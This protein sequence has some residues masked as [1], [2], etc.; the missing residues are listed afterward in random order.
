MA[1]PVRHDGAATGTRARRA[2][3]LALLLAAP[4]VLAGCHDEQ[5][6]RERLEGPTARLPVEPDQPDTPPAPALLDT[7]RPWRMP[8][9]YAGD[10]TDPWLLVTAHAVGDQDLTYRVPESWTVR[11]SGRA[12]SGTDEVES[13]ARL[14]NLR[15]SDISLATYAA[16]L[17]EGNPIYQYT[18]DDGHVVYVTR[19]EVALAPSDPDAPREVFHTAVV[20]VN[21]RIAKLDVRYDSELDWRYDE[22]A[23]AISGTLQ[24]RR[25]D[26]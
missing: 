16:Q 4:F 24:V 8:K 1:R 5:R 7:V 13:H 26:S 10:A 15:D 14:T 18:T 11:S 19:R 9:L 2:T 22:L 3:A 21:G 17:A 23:D 6:L 25:R 20:S 12:R